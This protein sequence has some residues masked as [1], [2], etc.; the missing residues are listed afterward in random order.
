MEKHLLHPNASAIRQACCPRPKSSTKYTR[1]IVAALKGYLLIA[2]AIFRLRSL[3]TQML[4]VLMSDY[5][6]FLYQA[7]NFWCTRVIQRQISC[8][9]HL[10]KKLAVISAHHHIA[11][12]HRQGPPQN[13]KLVP[14]SPQLTPVPPD[15]VSHRIAESNRPQ[16]RQC[17]SPS[18][19][20]LAAHQQFPFQMSAH[21]PVV[22]SHI[23]RSP[24]HVKADNS[25]KP[26]IK[27]SHCP[28]HAPPAGP[29]RIL[30]FP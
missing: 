12:R 2:L 25:I 20:F 29:D 24:T 30:S 5:S 28:N 8:S 22:M 13:T 3:G 11:I 23:G 1:N 18:S 19:A 14:D 17:E 9:K 7:A 21:I 4:P 26:A 6:H 10:G 16:L 15:N 27:L